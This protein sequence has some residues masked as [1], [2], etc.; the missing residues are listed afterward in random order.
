MA[1]QLATVEHL[2]GVP[3]RIGDTRLGLADSIESGL[4]VS[5]LD[6]LADEVAPND[7]RFKFRL[8]PKATLDRRKKSASRR[9]TSGEGDR[10]ERIAK[11]FSFAMGIYKDKAQVR[12]FLGRPHAMLAAKPPLNRKTRA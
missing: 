10:L 5:A 6:H 9:L 12:E 2:L 11:V 8:I 4:P 7:L 3:P 1:T